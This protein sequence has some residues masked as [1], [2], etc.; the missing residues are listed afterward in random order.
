MVRRPPV[1]LAIYSCG[2]SKQTEEKIKFKWIAYRT[3][4]E[5]LRVWKWHMIIAFY[6]TTSTDI[7]WNVLPYPS[8]N[9]SLYSQQQ[10]RNLKHYERGVCRHLFP[11]YLAPGSDTPEFITE[12]KSTESFNVFTTFLIVLSTPSLHIEIVTYTNNRTCQ[13]HIITIIIIISVLPKGKSFT[14]NSGTK[15]AILPKGRSSIANSG[16]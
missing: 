9:F 10:K 14:A 12:D 13:L 4:A 5:N 16:T 8:T 11:A 3:I 7:L 1:V 2:P 15:A 6:F